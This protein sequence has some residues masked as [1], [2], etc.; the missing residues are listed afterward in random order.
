MRR[1]GRLWR[2]WM[3]TGSR[4][5]AASSRLTRR[6]AWGSHLTQR[7]CPELTPRLTGKSSRKFDRR[8]VLPGPARTV[9]IVPMK[10]AVSPKPRWHPPRSGVWLVVLGALISVASAG[11]IRLLADLPAP[12]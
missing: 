8:E 5:G 11:A 7:T 4:A 10:E 6:V 3:M 1:R 2:G 9:M 12:A